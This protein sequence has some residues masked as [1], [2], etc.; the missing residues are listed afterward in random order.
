MTQEKIKIVGEPDVIEVQGPILQPVPFP[1]GGIHDPATDSERRVS[2]EFQLNRSPQQKWIDAF[3][4]LTE[5]QPSISPPKV[6]NQKLFWETTVRAVNDQRV[7]VIYNLVDQANRDVGN[8][9]SNEQESGPFGLS[10]DQ[11]KLKKRISDL[12]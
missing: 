8:I 5:L 2:L 11:E 1:G 3:R 9:S 7:Q 6:N 12:L 4:S 10:Y